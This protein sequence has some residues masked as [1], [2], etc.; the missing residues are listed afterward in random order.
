[1]EE[2]SIEVRSITCD[3]AP[4]NRKILSNV[5]SH[6]WNVYL[7]NPAH[8]RRIYWF[9]DA[10]HLLKLLRNNLLDSGFKFD[11]GQCISR[12][13]FQDLIQSEKDELKMLHK[14]TLKHLDVEN[15]ERQRVHLAAEL[16][17]NSTAVAMKMLFPQHEH[18]A[19]FVK[20]VNDWFDIFNSRH[21]NDTTRA[22]FGKDLCNQLHTLEKTYQMI[23]T[24]RKTGGRSF[25]LFR[26]VCE[27]RLTP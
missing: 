18:I 6:D 5:D 14:L 2:S 26:K 20:L 21:P 22:P 27:F 4:C 7:S 10:P 11:S 19:D 16:L 24:M 23:S 3:M 15:Q 12:K 17:S 1:M 8:P 9:Y 13:P 25:Y